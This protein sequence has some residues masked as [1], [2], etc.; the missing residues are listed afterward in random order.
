MT[1]GE[2]VVGGG[3]AK[4]SRRFTRVSGSAV[5]SRAQLELTTLRV[6]ERVEVEGT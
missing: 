1:K 5:Q 6:M 2:R 3:E 4:R